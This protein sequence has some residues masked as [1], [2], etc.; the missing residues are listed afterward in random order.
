M[1]IV[2]RLISSA[3]QW[4]VQPTGRPDSGI[5]TITAGA[6]PPLPGSP[7]FR[8]DIDAPRGVLNARLPGEWR[9]VPIEKPGGIVVFQSA[10]LLSKP[11][12]FN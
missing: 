10:P 5:Y 7:G 9:I 2:Q 1:F 4:F 3:I 8:R 11:C 6:F 12:V